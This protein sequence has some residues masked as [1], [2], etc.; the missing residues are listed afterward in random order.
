MIY[1]VT[2]NPSLDY[3]IHVENFELGK[4]NRTVQEDIYAGGKGINV[5]MVLKN[6]G[7]ETTAFGFLSGFTGQEIERLLKE[8][9]ISTEFIHIENGTSRIN[10]KIRSDVESE[11]NGM[12]PVIREKDL[13]LLYEQLDTLK[14]DDVLVL[15][16]S[17]PSGMPQS[18]YRDIMSRLQ[19][20][21]IKIA[22][23]A[24]KDLLMNVLAYHPF[25]I[26]PNNHEL[27]EIFDV[28][29]DSKE[30]AVVYA[31]ELQKKGAKNVIV[32]MAGEG[33]VFVGSDGSVFTSEAPHGVVKNSAHNVMQVQVRKFKNSVGAGD[34]MVAGFLAG[35]LAKGDYAEAFKMG[36]CTGSA[37]A[38]SDQ[39]ATREEVEQVR[40]SHI[41]DF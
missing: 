39:L 34:S 1:T 13:E 21:R 15:A 16:G 14:D 9:G 37:S 41:F 10:L 40:R 17:I 24:T 38:F 29:I 4:V 27:S 30:K 3:T 5:S 6:L 35:Y 2:F 36:L 22:V 8:K 19:S 11:I 33:A 12:G 7:Y 25:V 31:K 32:S 18:I 20:K 23:D 28:M 26:K